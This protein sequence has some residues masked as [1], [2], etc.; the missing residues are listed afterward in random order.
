[1]NNHTAL[2]ISTILK[3]EPTQLPEQHDPIKKSTRWL[4]ILILCLG[5]LPRFMWSDW[6][7]FKGQHPDERH[8]M[9]C[10]SSLA[11]P[12]SIGQFLNESASPLNPRNRGAHYFAYGTLPS[13]ML[14]GLTELGT[15]RDGLQVAKLSRGFSAFAD[16]CVIGL[17][18]LLAWTLYRR[19]SV[20]L[21]AAAF[22]AMCVLPIQHAHF[23]V[24]D[25]FAN[26]F[27][28]LALIFLARAWRS[29][30]WKDY[31]ATG[32]ALGLA[33]S[34]KISVATMG[35]PVALVALI[36][37]VGEK[38]RISQRLLTAIFRTAVFS[39]ATIITV[40]FALPDAFSGFW[41]WQL[42]PRWVANMR[43][44]VSISTGVIDIFFTRQFY[45]RIPLLWP[46][47]NMVA[48]GMGLALGLAAWA[49]W[50]KALWQ[51]ITKRIWAHSVLVLW[52]AVV[53]F[54]MGFTYQS[55]LRYFLPI[56]AP[57]C[58]LA[59]VFL[60]P[61]TFTYLSFLRKGL[62]LSVFFFT[63]AWA[64]AF[65]AIYQK[66]MT[67]IEASNWIYDNIP[68]GSSLACEHWDDTIP[69]PFNAE[70]T[71]EFYQYVEM[72]LYVVDN[73][74]KRGQLLEK[75]KSADYI[76]LASQKLRDSI[77]RMPHR[78]PLTIRYY[79]WLEDGTLGFDKVAEFTRPMIFLGLPISTRSAEEAF[80]VYD[81]PP[82]VIFKKTERYDPQKVVDLFN[83][84]SLDG[85]TDTREPA[86]EFKELP[87]EKVVKN[88]QEVAKA[89][90]SVLLKPARWAAAQNEGTWRDFFDRNSFSVRYPVIVWVLQ[91]ILL[92]WIGWVCLA[93][94]LKCLPDRG[95]A[96]AR[97]L[98]IL[99][100]CWILWL[101]ASSGIMKN[102]PA[103]YW[104]ILSF[105]ILITARITWVNRREWKNK[106][107]ITGNEGLAVE[108]VFWLGFTLFLCIRSLNP[109]VWHHSWGGEKPMEM[110]FLY[111]VIK[112]DH[113]PPMNPWYAGGFINYY[114]FGFVLCGTLIKSLG[115]LPEVG[116]N[117]CLATFFGMACAATM[118]FA[119]A[120]RP[121]NSR[122]VAF[123]ATAFVM[124]IGNLFQIRF[125]WNR[126]QLLGAP[127]H[128]LTFPIVSDLIRAGYGLFHV[129][130]E[131]TLGNYP[132]DLYWVAARAITGEDVAPVTEFPYW[133][134]LYGDLHP[135]LIALPYTL[136]L[137][138][139]LVA[140]IRCDSFKIR[141]A[142][143]FLLALILGFF[144]PTNTWDWPTY[145]ALTGL[146]LF[147]VSWK[148]EGSTL[149]GFGKAL[150]K[151]VALF[152]IM[153]AVGYAAFYPFHQHYVA[154]YGSFELWRGSRTSMRDY[155][156]I[157]GFFLFILG[158]VLVVAWNQREL[159]FTRGLKLWEII[160]QRGLKSPQHRYFWR[161]V[162]L[163][164]T[165]PASIFGA[166]FTLTLFI[167]TL[168]TL[169]LSFLPALLLLG[170]LVSIYL[171][172]H[173][174]RDPLQA[175]LPCLTSVA[176]T[177]SLFVEYVVLVGD[178][179]RMNTVFK[180]YYQVWVCFA[181]ASALALPK[182]MT[183]WGSCVKPLRNLWFGCFGILLLLALLFPILGTPAKIADRF[184]ST[185]PTLDG[186]V[187]AEKGVYVM[188]G[189]KIH[190]QPDLLAIRWLQDNIKGS[191]VILEMNTGA[192]LY[193]WGSRF[194]I[195]TGLPSLVGWG[196]HQRQQQAGLRKNLVEERISA[197]QTIYRTSNIEEAR[198]LINFYG[199]NL[200]IIGE[201]ERIFGTPEGIAKFDHMGFTK[202]YNHMGVTIYKV[203]Q[204]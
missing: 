113:F 146:T 10:T 176:F 190:L 82:V 121:Q 154:G 96:L 40:R 70:R 3:L 135:H 21:L 153:L 89:E 201:L 28:T 69:L 149:V 116:F 53:F 161:L 122:L 43:E 105:F 165:R 109:D 156:F 189:K 39:L 79:E 5:A 139:L 7:D 11:W 129:A 170:L 99:I 180:F 138:G 204:K 36:P 66:P 20:A 192:F 38:H 173:Y 92:Q 57:L 186:L 72:P 25:P 175:I 58:I 18:F 50:L 61:R 90:P 83:A 111:G 159:P 60:L 55:T 118:S 51:I 133:S 45:N 37:L 197:T 75:L 151:S 184:V 114:Y 152:L 199:V 174:R 73:P 126:L 14:K 63:L 148:R 182:A 81:H 74:E 24:V 137:L 177:L 194:S 106:F 124:L 142:L 41:P 112:S 86:E 52:V 155:L 98:A 131:A 196:W 46:W 107:K 158:S 16:T 30:G 191:P 198:N 168:I 115:I 4:L 35:L 147:L 84:V 127:D 102:Q 128:D 125:I 77:P 49:G 95:A 108:G 150:V 31:A 140:W 97:P 27:V 23:F 78:Y 34:C 17:V 88:N 171:V 130:G 2:T 100:P 8:I 195:H 110:T 64:F 29:G 157:Y 123:A 6:D 19:A 179:G 65:L 101:L 47:W 166:F 94:L 80:S 181:L 68:K 163:G 91:L 167:L 145:G 172:W 62:V 71:S 136:C 169:A 42:A 202:I 178:I 164:L 183:Y 33:I 85:V 87:I 203:P 120:F 48:W 141:A 1:M 144:W 93:P 187:F 143:F 134:F 44:V 185:A 9:M 13:T 26:F 103:T 132:A 160:T 32:V 117:L 193:S 22:Y 12:Q 119:R 56:Y 59:A 188:D 54:H 76:I 15:V 104:L 162:R 200:I 67:R